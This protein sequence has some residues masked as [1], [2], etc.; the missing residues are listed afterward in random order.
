M[1]MSLCFNAQATE[2]QLT[3]IDPFSI[4][5]SIIRMY[6]TIDVISRSDP[7]VL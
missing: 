5:V 7:G 3:N 2:G 6:G 4:K 1:P